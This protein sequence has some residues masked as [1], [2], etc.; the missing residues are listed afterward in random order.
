MRGQERVAQATASTSGQPSSQRAMARALRLWRSI[1][2]TSVLR[3]R[4]SCA[5]AAGSRQPPSVAASGRSVETSSSA[6]PAAAPATEVGIPPRY[7]V[8]ECRTKVEAVLERAAVDG[9]G[10]R[11]VDDR[12]RAGRV[13]AGGERG[14]VGE[15]QHRVRER[16]DVEQR[17][18]RRRA[19]PPPLLVADRHEGH[20]TPRARE[21]VA[22]QRVGVAV[23]LARRDDA[24]PGRGEREQGRAD[25]RHPGR[26]QQRVEALP[27]VPRS[28]RCRGVGRRVAEPAVPPGLL[29]RL[30]R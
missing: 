4:S 6:R 29:C 21:R 15:P 2:S 8:A 3:P 10:E 5:A 22:Q 16:L 12:A 23:E 26:E 14:Q 1:R 9:G 13:S 7:F 28:A 17:G 20:V 27:R 30:S 11:A 19:P 24:A 25:G 18:P